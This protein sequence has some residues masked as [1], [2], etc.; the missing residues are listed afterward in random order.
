M[1]RSDRPLR[2]REIVEVLGGELLGDADVVLEQVAPIE[3]AGPGELTFVAREGFGGRLAST[4]AGAVIL[5]P[6]LRDATTVPRVLASNP[7]AYFARASALLNPPRPVTAGIDPHAVVD[8]RARV[9]PTATVA[10]FATVDA[11][12]RIG[13]RAVISSGCR[14][15]RDVVIGDDSFLH[16]NVTVC[17]D[18]LIGRRCIL[19]PGSVIGA[20]GFGGAL[21]HGRWIRI[22]QIGRVVLGDD[23]EVGAN[24]TIDRGAMDDTVLGDGVKLDNQIQIGHN[25]TIGP[26]TAIAGCAGVAGSARLGARC[27][28]GG[29][30]I[31]LGHLCV[32]DDVQISAGTVVT[33]SIGRP[34]RYSGP[35]PFDEHRAWLR[36]AVGVR[37]LAGARDAGPGSPAGWRRRKASE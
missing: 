7:L 22:P 5:A 12:A 16:P 6:A 8:A 10:A 29:G 19:H 9:D 31:V 34:G 17:D 3:R 18:C 36:S 4:R 23:V 32:A 26:D 14:I 20:D 37:R 33:R 2:L 24:T 28:I 15:G 13:A 35:H 21:E 27:V 11:G 30:A 25:V 1:R